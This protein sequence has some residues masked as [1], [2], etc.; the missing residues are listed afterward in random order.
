MIG[1]LLV[2]ACSRRACTVTGVQ[3]AMFQPLTATKAW[4]AFAFGGGDLK[5]PVR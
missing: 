4:G 5:T 1:S 3:T 2:K